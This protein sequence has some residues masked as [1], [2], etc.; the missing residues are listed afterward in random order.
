MVFTERID[1]IKKN[2]ILKYYLNFLVKL[3][4][5][6]QR[7]TS[8]HDD[9]LI[10]FFIY[11]LTY[12]YILNYIYMLNYI[13]IYIYIINYNLYKNHLNFY[14]YY[15]FIIFYIIREVLN[16]YIKFKN[17]AVRNHIST[18]YTLKSFFKKLRLNLDNNAASIMK[19]LDV[20]E[21]LEILLNLKKNTEK[22]YKFLITN[23]P[24]EKVIY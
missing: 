21:Y 3:M 22:N 4:V 7:N 23:F 15:Y 9:K 13:Y 6:K 5:E 14:Y 10:F 20:N 11:I 12:I 24:S 1:S 2:L 18:L 19:Q 8:E 16:K 17:K